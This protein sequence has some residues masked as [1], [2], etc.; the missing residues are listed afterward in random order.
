MRKAQ[1]TKYNLE[2]KETRYLAS[3]QRMSDE[4]EEGRLLIGERMKQVEG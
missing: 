2:R 1:D 4:V 3:P